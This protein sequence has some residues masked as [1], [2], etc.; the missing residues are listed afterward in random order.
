MS[1]TVNT[2]IHEIVWLVTMQEAH[3]KYC[4]EQRSNQERYTITSNSLFK[5][6]QRE[7]GKIE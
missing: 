5:H 2:I 7:Y 1:R 3:R 6:V 4:S